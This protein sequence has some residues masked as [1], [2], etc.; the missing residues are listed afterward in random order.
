MQLGEG[1]HSPGSCAPQRFM[2]ASGK[3]ACR[4]H[5]TL[6][7]GGPGL[8]TGRNAWLAPALG[9]SWICWAWPGAAA[10][11]GSPANAHLRRPRKTRPSPRSAAPSSHD[12]LGLGGIRHS[13][14]A[15]ETRTTDGRNPSACK[16]G[17]GASAASLARR[18]GGV[19]SPRRRCRSIGPLF[20]C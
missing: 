18:V 16:P 17:A 8:C 15:T 10:R 1:I 20:C 12:A 19:T 3:Q 6:E 2:M 5:P 4:K 14:R 7:R 13:T 9:P 11:A